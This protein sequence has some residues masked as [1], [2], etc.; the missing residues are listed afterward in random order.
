MNWSTSYQES[1]AASALSWFLLG[2]TA[3][4]QGTSLLPA[5]TATSEGYLIFS[6]RPRLGLAVTLAKLKIGALI[7]P[8]Q[9]A[10]WPS[11]RVC[12][13]SIFWGQ[14]PACLVRK[15]KFSGAQCSSTWPEVTDSWHPNPRQRT[16]FQVPLK[17][18]S[19]PFLPASPDSDG[20]DP[21]PP[22]ILTSCS[23]LTGRSRIFNPI[24]M[25]EE[26]TD[27]EKFSNLTHITQVWMM[28]PVFV[29]WH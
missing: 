24:F 3:S 5:A 29:T 11:G 2:V 10:S 13:L 27:A 7:S 25:V 6:C 16:A 14:C 26:E 8:E 20:R 17:T 12:S 15:R 18:I 28:E 22:S 21:H 19:L 1:F 23:S 9:S 4:H